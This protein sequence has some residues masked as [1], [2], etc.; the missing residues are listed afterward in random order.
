M[1]LLSDSFSGDGWEQLGKMKEKLSPLLLLPAPSSSKQIARVEQ[2]WLV[3]PE[4]GRITITTTISMQ[5]LINIHR[6]ILRD[7]NVHFCAAI[8]FRFT[9]FSGMKVLRQNRHHQYSCLLMGIII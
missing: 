3:Q 4:N 6:S 1:S 7:E 8:L 5:K 9:R 2:V